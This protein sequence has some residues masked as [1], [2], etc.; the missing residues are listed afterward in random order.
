MGSRRWGLAD[1][2]G[3]HT[4]FPP[5]PVC[6]LA[7]RHEQ[8]RFPPSYSALATGL[9]DN[10]LISHAKCHLHKNKYNPIS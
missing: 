1:G 6:F 10:T 8:L 5:L 4:G 7:V 2:R 3:G 9:P